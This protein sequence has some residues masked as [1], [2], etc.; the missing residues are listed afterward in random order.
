MDN[1][2]SDFINLITASIIIALFLIINKAKHLYSFASF[3]IFVTFSTFSLLLINYLLLSLSVCVSF[4]NVY[5]I[6]NLKSDLLN[7][8]LSQFLIIFHHFYDQKFLG[9]FFNVAKPILFICFT[10]DSSSHSWQINL[11]VAP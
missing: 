1:F 2:S 3:Y 9:F 10:Y 11:K 4:V 6:N 7:S 8:H 5:N